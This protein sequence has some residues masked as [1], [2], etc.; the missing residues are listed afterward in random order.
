M[1]GVADACL[2]RDTPCSAPMHFHIETTSHLSLLRLPGRRRTTGNRRSEKKMTE[3]KTQR[4]RDTASDKQSSSQTSQPE[5]LLDQARGMA[6]QVADQAKS[7]VGN[8][9]TE[10]TTKSAAELSEFADALRHTSRRLEGNLVA[11][12]IASTADRVERISDA[13]DNTDVRAIVERVEDFARRE[14]LLFL[15]SAFAA[16]VLGAR[17]LRSGSSAVTGASSTE[18]E[19]S[20]E[21]RM[22]PTS[23]RVRSTAPSEARR[24]SS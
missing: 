6:S 22:K 15:G 13:L 14:P 1:H 17:F 7:A 21:V 20:R 10:R 3:P 8:R 5:G 9:L 24:L 12:L 11:P 19:A 2:R 16:G 4:S 18:F 23:G